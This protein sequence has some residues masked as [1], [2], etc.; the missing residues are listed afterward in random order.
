MTDDTD[1]ETFS[2]TQ[3]QVA[4]DAASNAKKMLDEAARNLGYDDIHQMMQD[5]PNGDFDRRTDDGVRAITNA[6]SYL[7]NGMLEGLVDPVED[8]H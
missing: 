1:T 6:Y 2:D 3:R 7:D 5:R 4:Y 8:D